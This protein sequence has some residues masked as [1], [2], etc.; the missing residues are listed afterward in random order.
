MRAT[1]P[2]LLLVLA[3]AGCGERLAGEPDRNAPSVAS[4]PETPPVTDRPDPPD[5]KSAPPDRV[6]RTDE[7][8]RRTLTPTQYRVLREKGTEHPYTGKYWDAKTP[9][10]YACAGCGLE[11]FTSEMKFDSHCGWPSFDRELPG[12]RIEKVED[13]TLGMV[14]T[15]VLCPRCGGHLGHLFDDGPTE[16]GMRYCI[17]S[18][19]IDLR[20][21]PGAK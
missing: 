7:E 9:G 18:A 19:S 17:N 16:T 2:A 10:T 15:E 6:V 14:R 21:A 3:L 11:L 1:A 5:A 4:T 20:P 13:R 8:W 12:A